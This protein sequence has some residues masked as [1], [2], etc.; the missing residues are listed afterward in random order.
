MKEVVQIS[1]QHYCLT[2]LLGYDYVFSNKPGKTNLVADALFRREDPTSTQYFILSIPSYDFLFTLLLKNNT[3]LALQELYKEVQ[4]SSKQHPT[5]K[6][7]NGVL[8]Y[9]GKPFL[10]KTSSLKHLFYKNFS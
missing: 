5:L 1:D 9:K 4:Q 6:I 8:Y 3:F 2:K 10:S 7:I